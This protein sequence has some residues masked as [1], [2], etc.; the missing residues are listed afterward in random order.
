MRLAA[1]QA[2]FDEGMFP[3]R[4]ADGVFG[5]DLFR[6]RRRLREDA[7]LRRARV[8]LQIRGE[9]RVRA[10]KGMEADRLIDL[11][12]P[13]LAEG[14]QK[15]L[16]RRVRAREGEQPAR[17]AVEA[18]DKPRAVFLPQGGK[19]RLGRDAGVFVGDEDVFVPIDDRVERD[20]LLARG[21][22]IGNLIPR[23]E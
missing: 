11:F 14:G 18:V 23:G 8:L 16:L 5:D 12:R 20:G 21:R 10:G 15:F 13:P 7:H 3:F 22:V 6:A 2:H 9:Q 17:I 19:E 1:V 4:R